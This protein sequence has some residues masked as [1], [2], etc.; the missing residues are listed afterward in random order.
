MDSVSLYKRHI[1]LIDKIR[2]SVDI[3]PQIIIPQLGQVGQMTLAYLIK[4][5]IIKLFVLSDIVYCET[6]INNSKYRICK[7]VTYNNK[8][9]VKAEINVNNVYGRR[10]IQI[11]ILKDRCIINN[12][13][14]NDLID[15]DQGVTYEFSE[16]NDE[17]FLFDSI[18]TNIN[19]LFNNISLDENIIN[20]IVDYY[21]NVDNDN[22]FSNN[23]NIN[24]HFGDI[25][26]DSICN[27]LNNKTLLLNLT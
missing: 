8:N 11:I 27:K 16:I 14:K 21:C 22:Y 17:I 18:M 25:I 2:L 20:E 4:T 19:N 24:N 3:N 5:D 15:L 7:L 13:L 6:F 10:I 1:Y 12:I 9:V 23:D 26:Y